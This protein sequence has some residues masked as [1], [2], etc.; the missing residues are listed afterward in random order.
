MGFL[1]DVRELQAA[2]LR[3]HMRDRLLELVGAVAELYANDAPRL[4]IDKRDLEAVRK[5]YLKSDVAD[6]SNPH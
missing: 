6:P 3:I 4:V 5:Y 1:N 2:Q